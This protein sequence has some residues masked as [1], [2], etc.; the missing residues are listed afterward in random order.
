MRKNDNRVGVY[1][2]RPIA[3]IFLLSLVIVALSPQ[4]SAG[5]CEVIPYTEWLGQKRYVATRIE[6]DG[7]IGGCFVTSG[8]NHEQVCDYLNE[9]DATAQCLITMPQVSPLSP[10]ERKIYLPIVYG[11]GAR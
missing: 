6:R 8:Y 3:V 2:M 1:V 11:N 4:A 7:V 9:L 5:S 10:I